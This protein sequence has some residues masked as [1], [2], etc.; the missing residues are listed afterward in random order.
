MPTYDYKCDECGHT[1]EKMQLITAKPLKKCPKCKKNKLKR[2][3]GGGTGIIFRN[4][5]PYEGKVPSHVKFGPAP[6]QKDN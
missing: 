2:L 4:T 6:K 1:F 3:I 5:N